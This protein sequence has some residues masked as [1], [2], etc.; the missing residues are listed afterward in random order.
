MPKIAVHA[1]AAERRIDVETVDGNA[2]G[3]LSIF[4]VEEIARDDLVVVVRSVS[5]GASAVAVANGPDA[6]D[7]RREVFV[8]LEVAAAVE[9]QA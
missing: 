5:E 9:L 8:D 3:D 6:G 4:A 2:I 7:R 1:D